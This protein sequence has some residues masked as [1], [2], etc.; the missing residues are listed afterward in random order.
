MFLETQSYINNF[1]ASETR[2]KTKER[3]KLEY[4]MKANKQVIKSGIHLGRWQSRRDNKETKD[5]SGVRRSKKNAID[6]VVGTTL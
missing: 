3:E 6:G 2:D 4:D 5:V 1:L